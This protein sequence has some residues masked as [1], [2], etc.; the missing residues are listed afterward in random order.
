MR[1]I[2]QKVLFT[3]PKPR[4]ILNPLPVDKISTNESQMFYRD[5]KKKP[6][7][8]R[9]LDIIHERGRGKKNPKT[10]LQFVGN[11]SST[12]SVPQVTRPS[13]TC[14]GWT[15]PGCLTRLH[16]HHQHHGF[17]HTPSGYRSLGESCRFYNLLR[18][19]CSSLYKKKKKSENSTTVSMLKTLRS[20]PLRTWAPSLILN[21]ELFLAFHRYS[22]T[23]SGALVMPRLLFLCPH[24]LFSCPRHFTPLHSLQTASTPPP[25]IGDYK[26]NFSPFCFVLIPPSSVIAGL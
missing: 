4:C 16:Q 14:G 2:S 23:G 9:Y 15:M 1:W 6:N 24:P 17:D 3:P 10:I 8:I 11:D 7:M 26:Q 20:A 12:L 22:C 21:F 19:A 25:L 13:P 18:R 5:K